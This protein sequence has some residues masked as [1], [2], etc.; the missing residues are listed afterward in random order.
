MSIVLNKYLILLL[1]QSAKST[2][3]DGFGRAG[4]CVYRSVEGLCCA[5]GILIPDDKYDPNMETK[6]W[7]TLISRKLVPKIYQDLITELQQVHDLYPAAHWKSTLRHAAQ[8]FKLNPSQ[9]SHFKWNNVHNRYIHKSW[10]LINLSTVN[11]KPGEKYTIDGKTYEV[12]TKGGGK[13]KNWSFYYFAKLL[14]SSS[15]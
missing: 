12:V 13:F 9:L 4:P 2:K 6:L 15:I 8:N 1:T 5:A 11:A 14:R 3:Y 10:Q 7:G